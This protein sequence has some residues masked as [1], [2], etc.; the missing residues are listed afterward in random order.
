[1]LLAT[2]WNVLMPVP[3]QNRGCWSA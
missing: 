3:L 1:M 2:C